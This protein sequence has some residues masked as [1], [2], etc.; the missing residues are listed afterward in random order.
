[1]AGQRETF[2]GHSGL[3]AELAELESEV[4]IEREVVGADLVEGGDA[5][6]AIGLLAE[7][8]RQVAP[9]VGLGRDRVAIATHPRPCTPYIRKPAPCSRKRIRL[10]PTSPVE[11]GQREL[12]R[13]EGRPGLLQLEPSEAQLALASKRRDPVNEK[14]GEEDRSNR[15][16]RRE[17]WM[18]RSGDRQ[19]LEQQHGA[20]REE[21]E[22]EGDD[23][24]GDGARQLADRDAPACEHAVADRAPAEEGQAHVVAEDEGDE[25][26]QHD[27]WIRERT[28]DPAQRERVVAGEQEV[29]EHREGNRERHV[30]VGDRRQVPDHV[31][32]VVLG[33]LVMKDPGRQCEQRESEKGAERRCEALLH[34]APRAGARLRS[35]SRMRCASAA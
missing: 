25:R 2:E 14:R 20:E 1:M 22:P 11:R 4:E 32:V 29:A 16:A 17:E 9:R 18:P 21:A 15:P 31:A 13:R 28:P 6:V 8:P 23:V 30:S 5:A 34:G 26:G 35:P 12:R 3:L 33:E 7:A 19:R 10:S 24:E 27:W